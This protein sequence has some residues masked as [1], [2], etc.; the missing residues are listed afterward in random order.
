MKLIFKIR[1]WNVTKGGNV[2]YLCKFIDKNEIQEKL[3]FL[4]QDYGEI[5]A[6][7]IIMWIPYGL[8]RL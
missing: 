1:S 8:K 3:T 6:P 4:T 5:L 7:S 2:A